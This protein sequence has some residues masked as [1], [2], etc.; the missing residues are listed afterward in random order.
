MLAEVL[1]GPREPQRLPAQLIQPAT[2]K[3][4]WLLD[5]AAAG[6]GESGK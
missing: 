2:G 6:M 3:V 5:A 1:E 4:T